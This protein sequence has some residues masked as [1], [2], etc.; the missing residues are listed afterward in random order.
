MYPFICDVKH[1]L[2]FGKS[3]MNYKY[4]ETCSERPPRLHYQSGPD[5]EVPEFL[6]WWL[7][8]KAFIILQYQCISVNHMFHISYSNSIVLDNTQNISSLTVDYFKMAFWITQ[9]SDVCSNMGSLYHGS[10]Y[11]C[12]S[13]KTRIHLT[14]IFI[15]FIFKDMNRAVY[16]K[17]CL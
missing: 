15:W 6:V 5:R 2:S 11:S 9:N 12:N 1:Q 13:L 16:S 14:L 17:T 10:I 4:N 3:H 7:V 8:C